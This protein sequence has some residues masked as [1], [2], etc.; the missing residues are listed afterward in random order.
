MAQSPLNFISQ[1]TKQIIQERLKTEKRQEDSYIEAHKGCSL[2][3]SIR[4]FRLVENPEYDQ[5]NHQWTAPAVFYP[6]PSKSTVQQASEESQSAE[7][8]TYLIYFKS[9]TP[10][11]CV[12][13]HIIYA[14]LRKN[15]EALYPDPIPQVGRIVKSSELD[16]NKW[17]YNVQPTGFECSS[18]SEHLRYL[19]TVNQESLFY[20]LNLCEIENQET[21]SQGNGMDLGCFV[22][23]GSNASFLAPVPV[24]TLVFMFGYNYYSDSQNDDDDLNGE[25]DKG[26]TNKLYLFQFSNQ[27]L[28]QFAS[29]L[30]AQLPDDLSGPSDSRLTNSHSIQM[31]IGVGLNGSGKVDVYCPL[32]QEGDTLPKGT[33]VVLSRNMETGAWDIIEASCTPSDLQDNDDSNGS[34]NNDPPTPHESPLEE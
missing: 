24:G 4:Q 31:S 8:Q 3:F 2:F 30:V 27:P 26:E 7:E 22:P 14:V 9:E 5:D 20:A 34:E 17:C 21:G 16:I 19:H 18:N 11:A 15:W 1:Q 10:P 23:E 13:G 28:Y 25:N 33:I 6:S 32:L 29:H 12:A